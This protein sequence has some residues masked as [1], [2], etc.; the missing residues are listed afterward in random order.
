MAYVSAT[1]SSES[2]S[3]ATFTP[4]LSDHESGDVLV[5]WAVHYRL[6][7]TISIDGADTSNFTDPVG[8]FDTKETGTGVTNCACAL[9][10]CEAASSSEAGP[11]LTQNTAA[12]EWNAVCYTI[13]DAKL[14]DVIEAANTGAFSSAA[15]GTFPQITPTNA[16]CLVLYFQTTDVNTSRG[17]NY[18]FG[19]EGFNNFQASHN[20]MVS[21]GAIQHHEA[22]AT[23]PAIFWA[24]GS[25]AHDGVQAVVAINTAASTLEAGVDVDNFN[26]TM[27]FPNPI[28]S[29][30]A[31]LYGISAI[32]V[33]RTSLFDGSWPFSTPINISTS[34]GGLAVI[35]DETKGF[36][37]G[38]GF[39]ASNSGL[40]AGQHCITTWTIPS[41]S[42]TGKHLI[43]VLG[44]SQGGS[45]VGTVAEGGTYIVLSDGTEI[46]VY[47]I[48]AVDS[49]PS[50]SVGTIGFIIDPANP[51]YESANSG[52]MNLGAIV[53]MGV[54]T[55]VSSTPTTPLIS[56]L[57]LLDIS[58][59]KNII[60]R[61]GYF[62]RPLGF[63]S[64]FGT[65][66]SQGP[67]AQANQRGFTA[68][69]YFTHVPL[70]IGDGSVTTVT[71][72]S[73]TSL[74]F[75][76]AASSKYLAYP[77]NTGALQF[78]LKFGSSD[79]FTS[80]T[81]VIDMGDYHQ[82]IVDNT[83]A[84]PSSSSFNGMT[85][86]NP[87]P[88]LPD[89]G[90]NAYNGMT[91]LGGLELNFLG[92]I[93]TASA[94]GGLTFSNWD[95]PYVV[96][97]TSETEFNALRGSSYF[98]NAVSIKITG[99]QTGTWSGAGMT[100]SG[101][102][103]SYDIEYTGTTDFTIEFD[104]GSGFSQGRVDNSAAVTAGNTGL[105]VS[106]PTQALRI[107]PDVNITGGIRYF[108]GSPDDQTPNDSGTGDFLDYTYSTTDPIDIEVVEQGYVPVNQQNVTPFD[109]TLTIEMDIDEAYNASHSL[110]IVTH[111]TY[112]RAT[113]AFAILA[114]QNAFDVRSS[115]ADTIR[116]NSSY[117]NTP[118]LLEAKPGGKR[119]DL[120][121]GATITS[122]AT[123]KGAGME[124]YDAADAINPVEKWYAVQSVNDISGATVIYRQTNSGDF[125]VGSLTN[126][127]FDEALQFYS[128][129]D[130]DGTP[131]TE[132]NSYLLIKAL[133]VGYRQARNDVV[134]GNGGASLKADLYTIG[135]APTA[136]DYAGGPINL[137]A[138][139]TLVAGGTVGGK[140]FAYKWVDA[141]T[142]SGTD[143][144]DWINYMGA[145]SPNGVIPGGTGLRW[146]EMPDMV[147]YVTGGVET[148]QGYREGATP[149]LVGFYMERGGSDHPDM[150]RAQA[151]DGTYYT[152]ATSVQVLAPNLIDGTLV[153][154]ADLDNPGTWLDDGTVVSGGGGYSLVL[155]FTG[156]KNIQ[157]R[158]GHTD[159][160]IVKENLPLTSGGA[161]YLGTPAA[162]EFYAHHAIDG[163]TVTGYALDYI[164]NEIDVV[165]P[166]VFNA[167]QGYAWYKYKMMT[168]ATALKRFAG[169]L[170]Y[171]SLGHLRFD[172]VS[173]DPIVGTALD[174]KFDNITSPPKE[175]V[176]SSGIRVDRASGT[177]PVRT[178][179]TSDAGIDVDW[180]S[181]V[182][183]ALVTT[184]DQSLNLATAEQ[185]LANTGV[186]STRMAEMDSIPAILADTADMQ[187][188]VAD[189]H[190]ADG[191]DAGDPVTLSGDGE[192][193]STVTTA[194]LTKV[195]T[196]TSIERTA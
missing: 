39:T 80:G 182:Y 73:N 14:T 55:Y 173:V 29:P 151:D 1:K 136:H 146:A 155:P 43:G 179:T 193:S 65:L 177:R 53:G 11:L 140:T 22:S 94:F 16:G 128:D 32:S 57:H 79:V 112:D 139:M 119:I 196:P 162:D 148:A 28:A 149:T 31:A 186:T 8:S 54:M 52:A 49:S 10:I 109:G 51:T 169:L 17:S 189:I 170:D 143:I 188:K 93:T 163:S 41:T 20:Y 98:G 48:S 13:K 33:D 5:I 125:T 121:D 86:L 34:G 19:I 36:G 195:I 191:L 167:L 164:F 30:S 113:K 101:G 47:R 183:V 127:V 105:T 187:P 58:G 18:E 44:F 42:F 108:D 67:Q 184:S 68:G 96:T 176:E 89:L 174:V 46:A 107:N 75:P 131:A 137:S 194:R 74:S 26:A 61:G 116:T 100:V 161:T 157:I 7:T 40:H 84:G 117:Y 62:G 165:V 24:G 64:V 129:P 158:A 102:G 142:N 122:M 87:D 23:T 181:D 88:T 2:A 50:A 76:G 82:F 4:E 97:V 111:Y 104:I 147:I 138:T 133:R 180:R 168:D 12:D 156:N 15:S 110:T 77:I 126:N 81:C 63:E 59:N 166:D 135:L 123:W 3:A 124:R 130:H 69:Q 171:L 118:L 115:M 134:A 70:Q 91:L 35:R 85:V 78:R 66:I 103:G 175:I 9:F 190:N 21:S 172:D 160:R 95:D 45:R 38:I 141:G 178:P 6:G 56:G 83:T 90:A 71:D 144:A 99:N 145:T 120:I 92:A 150:V 60:S 27:L 72:L 114:D 37:Q 25:G 192:T 185:A 152:P 106:T 159:K 153:V 154:V 132:N